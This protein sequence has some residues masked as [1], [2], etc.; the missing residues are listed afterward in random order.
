MQNIRIYNP[1]TGGKKSKEAMPEE[2]QMLGFLDFMYVQQ[3]NYV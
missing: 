2:A 3:G 1:H